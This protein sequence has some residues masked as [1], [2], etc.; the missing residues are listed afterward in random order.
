MKDLLKQICD[1]K[2]NDCGG[3]YTKEATCVYC[4]KEN[5]QLKDNLKKLEE[6]F[7]D[8]KSDDISIENNMLLSL[9]YLEID[10]INDHLEEIDY[11]YM[12]KAKIE[13]LRNKLIMG[14]DIFEDDY[15]VMDAVKR[16]GTDEDK[17]LLSKFIF[18]NQSAGKISFPYDY[19]EF[20]VRHIT[21]NYLKDYYQINTKCRI[22][23]DLGCSAFAIGNDVV[24]DRKHVDSFYESRD[25]MI[26]VMLIHESCHVYQNAIMKKDYQSVD[27]RTTLAPFYLLEAKDKVLSYLDRGYYHDNY[28]NLTFE[29]EAYAEGYIQARD[30]YMQY[31]LELSG[32]YIE[33]KIQELKSKMNNFYRVYD[34]KKRSLIDIFEDVIVDHP[35]MLDNYPILKVEYKIEDKKVIRKSDEEF[36]MEKLETKNDALYDSLI[37]QTKLL[38]REKEHTKE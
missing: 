22:E 2:C 30:W 24:I 19:V 32:E 5:S 21:E 37:A 18:L 8:N 35:E 17:D 15:K 12:I 27:A 1:C 10:Y 29:N 9:K 28:D 23:D 4:G 20:A 11:E 26:L 38:Q 7:S 6:I 25:P 14:G 16:I 36:L 34:G 3:S 33:N 13:E 31:G